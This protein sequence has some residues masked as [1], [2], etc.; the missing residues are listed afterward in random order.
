MLALTGCGGHAK[1]FLIEADGMN[2]HRLLDWDFTKRKEPKILSSRD[3]TRFSCND[4]LDVNE[5]LK[6]FC[7]IILKSTAAAA[8]AVMVLQLVSFDISAKDPCLSCIRKKG[9]ALA[10]DICY[11]EICAMNQF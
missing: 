1:A 2:C 8:A 9:V 5:G 7:A 4:T 3:M 10:C 11:A 6:H